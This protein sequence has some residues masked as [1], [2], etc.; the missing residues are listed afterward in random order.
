MKRAL[1]DVNVLLTLLDSDHVD[2]DRASAWLDDEIGDGWAS[3]PITENGFV[4]IMPAPVPEPGVSNGGHRVA[5][6]SL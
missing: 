2:H 5:G 3:C 1:L 6:P 4:R